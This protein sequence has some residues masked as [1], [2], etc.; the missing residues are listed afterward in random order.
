MGQRCF[1]EEVRQG[2]KATSGGGWG[3][4]APCPEEIGE[5]SWGEAEHLHEAD[6][7]PTALGQCYISWEEGEEA[8]DVT[9]CCNAKWGAQEDQS[10]GGHWS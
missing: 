4:Q 1:Q 3:C 7:A 9:L 8:G 5:P 2:P 10:H 6:H